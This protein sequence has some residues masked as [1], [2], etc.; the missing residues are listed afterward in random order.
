M[1]TFDVGHSYYTSDFHPTVLRRVSTD[2]VRLTSRSDR[3]SDEC[4]RTDP[5]CSKATDHG[6]GRGSG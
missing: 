6:M 3:P 4:L 1:T 5:K 2:G